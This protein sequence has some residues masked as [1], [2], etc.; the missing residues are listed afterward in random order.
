M[1]Y[2]ATYEYVVSA[3][4]KPVYRTSRVLLLAGYVLYVAVLFVIGFATSILA[5]MLAIVPLTTWILVWFTWRYVAVEYEYSLTGGVMTVSKIFGGRTRKR[6]AEIAIKDVSRIAPFEGDYIAE[7]ERYA[8]ERTVDITADLQ[9]PNVYF[10]LYETAEKR[11]GI[12]YFEATEKA[13]RILNYY[14]RATV[15]KRLEE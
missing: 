4:K 13:L 9:R 1:D 10:A 5:P 6:V 8:P 3:K 11:R 2:T 14:N 15:V 12:L 7:A